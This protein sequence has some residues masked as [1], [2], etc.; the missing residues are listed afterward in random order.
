MADNILFKQGK[1]ENIGTT[2]LLSG[3]V[4]FAIDDTNVDNDII[5]GSIF[6]DY[7]DG[8]T[9]RRAK[10]NA[11][12]HKLVSPIKIKIGET[13]KNI[14][15]NLTLADMT[16][17]HAEIGANISNFSYSS[18][19]RTIYLSINESGTSSITIPNATS[20]T[21]GFVN[22]GSQTFNGAKTFYRNVSIGSISSTLSSPYLNLYQKKTTTGSQTSTSYTCTTAVSSFVTSNKSLILEVTSNTYTKMGDLTG[23][24]DNNATYYFS[25]TGIFYP[26]GN[27]SGSLGKASNYWHS[28]F[29]DSIYGNQLG[30]NTRYWNE[31]YINNVSIYGKLTLNSPLNIAIGNTTKSFNGNE[32]LTWTFNE[33]SADISRFEWQEIQNSGLTLFLTANGVEKTA[34][35]PEASEDFWGVVTTTEQTFTGNKSLSNSS[36]SIFN[37]NKNNLTLTDSS[38][39]MTKEN[40]NFNIAL[41]N[42]NVKFLYGNSN[43][44]IMNASSLYPNS[45]VAID[46]GAVN[47]RWKNIYGNVIGSASSWAKK[48]N[49]SISNIANNG[50]TSIDGSEDNYTLYLPTE[51]EGLNKISTS[52]SIDKFIFNTNNSTYILGAHDS[53]NGNRNILTDNNYTKYVE[54]FNSNVSRGNSNTPIYFDNGVV[55]ECSLVNGRL[56]LNNPNNSSSSILQITSSDIT[57]EEGYIKSLSI[58]DT[59][60]IIGSNSVTADNFIGKAESAYK[61]TNKVQFSISNTANNNFIEVDGSSSSYALNIPKEISGFTSIKINNNEVYHMGNIVYSDSEP[62]NPSSGMIWLKPTSVSS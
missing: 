29:I 9:P 60:V 20:T 35:I 36:F 19:S 39:S 30:D 33:I 31:A 16:W 4:L 21:T 55:T 23:Y 50:V 14:S 57:E 17:N 45:N 34:I 11:D 42:D 22:T 32:D 3:Q 13:E 5:T 43:E 2:D 56:G 44:I 51:I 7:T 37:G 10:L 41:D 59:S 12:A 61:W 58:L 53:N 1:I 62:S 6:L 46:L 49:F 52:T 15:S 48:P 47:N 24:T 25:S 54:Q 26:S 18:S 8:T 40:S 38:L 27:N 28:A